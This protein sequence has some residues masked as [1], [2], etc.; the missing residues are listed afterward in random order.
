MSRGSRHDAH[1]GFFRIDTYLCRALAEQIGRGGVP[2]SAARALLGLWDLAARAG[3]AV[4]TLD[5]D[6]WRGVTFRFHPGEL[7]DVLGTPRARRRQGARTLDFRGS[8]WTEIADAL[9]R[10]SEP[11]T[12]AH[13]QGRGRGDGPTLVSGALAEVS[14]TDTGRRLVTL[15]PYNGIET[16]YYVLISRRWLEARPRLGEAETRLALWLARRHRGGRRNGRM[17]HTWWHTLRPRELSEGGVLRARRGRPGEARRGLGD[18]CEALERL[19]A[20]RVIDADSAGVEVEL[21]EGFFH[22]TREDRR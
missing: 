19:G 11:V 16:N 2:L 10:L 1:D 4:E 9:E 15:G 8:A 20:I 17:R 21:G 6:S 22:G 18:A 7:L 13:R 14:H 5:A 12:F 3:N